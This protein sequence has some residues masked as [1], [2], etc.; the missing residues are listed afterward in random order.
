[1]KKIGSSG[2]F[3]NS[4]L[5][6]RAQPDIDVAEPYRHEPVAAPKMTKQPS[7][8]LPNRSYRTLPWS[9][10]KPIPATAKVAIETVTAPVS[11]A[12]S[13]VT[14]SSIGANLRDGT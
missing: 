11:K 14:A 12:T 13:Q 4:R 1:M 9:K 7:I 5:P 10:E 3:W 2:C 6:Y 8:A